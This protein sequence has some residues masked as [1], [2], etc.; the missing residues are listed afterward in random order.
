MIYKTK[1][2]SEVLL[3]GTLPC[4]EHGVALPPAAAA[5]AAV[6]GAVGTLGETLFTVQSSLF[7]GEFSVSSFF[8]F[9]FQ[10][11]V[12]SFQCSVLSV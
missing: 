11:S 7:W 1:L 4:V 8:L 9:V 5:G 12:F 6:L 3:S 2:F 10:C